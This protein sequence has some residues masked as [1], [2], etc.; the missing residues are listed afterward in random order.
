MQPKTILNSSAIALVITLLA[1]SFNWISLAFL[2]LC[3]VAGLLAFFAL[4]L[5]KII[6]INEELKEQ[7][8]KEQREALSIAQR[9]SQFL[10]NLSHEIRTPLNGINGMLYL[11]HNTKLNEEQSDLLKI[12][13]NSSDHLVE[14][15]NMI[16]DYS[17]LQAN[18]MK[19]NKVNF[20]LAEKLESLIEMFRFQAREKDLRLRLDLCNEII[21]KRWVKGDELRLQQVLINLI[22][23]AL[24]FTEHGYVMLKVECVVNTDAK[25][26]LYFEVRDTGQGM[27]KVQQ[28]KLFQAFEQAHSVAQGTGLGLSISKSLV[29]LMGGQLH[30]ESGENLGSRF[31][32]SIPMAFSQDPKTEQIETLTELNSLKGSKVL[33]VEDDRL[34]YE[35]SKRALNRSGLSLEWAQNGEEALSLFKDQNFD[36]ILMDLQMPIM[37]GYEA[38]DKIRKSDKFHRH[39]IPII[40]ITASS[41]DEIADHSS[42]LSFDGVINKPFKVET[43]QHILQRFVNHG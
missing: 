16:L 20:D 27:S 43:I 11:M 30:L 21:A 36:L 12:A 10:A 25:P 7:A 19:L 18:K 15:V 28:K 2:S 3:L 26:M 1:I 24:K 31:Y 13:Q 14:L 35:V 9:K 33:L 5:L 8:Q 40:A 34:N 6:S 42:Q 23:N 17:K 39:E 41:E 37:D 4:R 38:T 32:F 22:N 29:E